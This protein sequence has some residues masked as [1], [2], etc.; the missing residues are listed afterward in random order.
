MKTEDLHAEAL[1]RCDGEQRQGFGVS[2][3]AMHSRYGRW[4]LLAAM[5]A[6]LM[7]FL[8]VRLWLSP[9]QTCRALDWAGRIQVGMHATD[10]ALAMRGC[11]AV[12]ETDCTFRVPKGCPICRT[13]SYKVPG[14]N[15]TLDID[16]DA[17][18][19]VTLVSVVRIVPWY[20]RA[21]QTLQDT[22]PPLSNLRSNP[23]SNEPQGLD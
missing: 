7:G 8:G 15:W 13:Q 22:I 23:V 2:V 12:L 3:D 4:L 20:E 10:V 17:A 18:D 16:F 14:D 1:R 6:M 21:W 19:K 5:P 11:V 9:H